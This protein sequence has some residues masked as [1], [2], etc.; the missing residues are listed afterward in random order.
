MFAFVLTF[1][2]PLTFVFT[3]DWTF[4]LPLTFGLTFA[5]PLTFVFAFHL[6]CFSTFIFF[7]GLYMESVLK[8]FF[9]S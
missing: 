1:G 2:L 6:T 9:I 3:F 7:E 5:L 8:V 4:G